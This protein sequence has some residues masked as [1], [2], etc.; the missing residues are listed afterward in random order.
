MM[1]ELITR[2]TFLKT[3]GAAVLA[4]AAGS[5]LAGCENSSDLLLNVSSLPSVSS[6]SCISYNGNYDIGMGAFENCRSNST[7]ESSGVPHFYLYTAVSFQ[8]VDNP[9]TVNTSDFK[10]SFSNSKLTAKNAS[11]LGKYTLD[12]SKDKYKASTSQTVNA[13]NNTIPLWVD[14]GSYFDVPT[15]YIGAFTVT[16]KGSVLFSYANSTYNPTPSQVGK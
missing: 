10:F 4:A 6:D 15:T 14:L 11:C 1:S 5:M 8:H 3:T 13:G 12:S 9:F 7:H 2:R 16:Y